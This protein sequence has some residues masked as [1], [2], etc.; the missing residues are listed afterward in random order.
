MTDRPPKQV[1]PGRYQFMPYLTPEAYAA[2][3][4]DVVKRGVQTPIDVD[5]EGVI[6]EG[7][8]RAH[9]EPGRNEP[10]PGDRTHS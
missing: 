2:L 3:K 9:C 4:A 6:L 1:L 5:E 10:P 8:W 7:R